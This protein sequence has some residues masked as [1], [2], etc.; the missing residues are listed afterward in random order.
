MKGMVIPIVIGAF[1]A[2]TK[3]LVQGLDD[4]EIKGRVKAIQNIT[5]L[6]SVGIL[7]KVIE[8]WGDLLS[9]KLQWET[10]G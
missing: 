7:K 2:V 1:G 10:I 3:R 9:L 4:L 8:A 5:L 6:R